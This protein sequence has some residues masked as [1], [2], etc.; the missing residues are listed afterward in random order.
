MVH[1]RSWD[2]SGLTWCVRACVPPFFRSTDHDAD[3]ETDTMQGQLVC[4]GV[5]GVCMVA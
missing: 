1:H 3:P 2:G 4:H 5:I